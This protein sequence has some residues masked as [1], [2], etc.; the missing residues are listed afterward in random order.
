MSVAVMG[1]ILA[2]LA[3]I[4]AQ[5]LPNWSRGFAGVQRMELLG[6]GIE[7]IVAD[8]T[9]AEPVTAN[10][11]TKG[12][13][14]EGS[15][16]SVTFVR[17]ALGPDAAPGLEIVRLAETAD[18]RGLA[19]VRSRAPFVPI[20]NAQTDGLKVADPV[21]LARAPFRFSFSYA[22]QD[23]IWQNKWFDHARLPSAV[24]II[25]RH[26]ATDRVLYVSTA[27]LLHVNVI[28]ECAQAKSA[29]ECVAKMEADG[30]AQSA[31]KPL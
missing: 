17:R 14:F 25:V 9:A 5:W 30:S 24:R 3:T 12:V 16:L 23:R 27:A 7:R 15:E 22:G 6:L 2:A 11:T 21:V 26:T 1:A 8:L 4:T 29:R 31:E 13:L 28:A 19:L 10:G 18:Q 20:E